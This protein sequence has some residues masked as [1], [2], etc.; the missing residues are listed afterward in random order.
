MVAVSQRLNYLRDDGAGATLL[1]RDA[2]RGLAAATL[3]TGA[4][5]L[6]FL[7]VRTLCAA[8]LA[9]VLVLALRWFYRRWL[10]GVTGDV[11]GACGELVEVAVLVAF[12]A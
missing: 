6:A 12:A 5:L 1:S 8:A 11:I 3:V 10:G 7:A 4:A 9:V 2:N